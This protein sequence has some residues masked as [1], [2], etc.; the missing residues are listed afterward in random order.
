[1]LRER[2]NPNFVFDYKFFNSHG[3]YKKVQYTV[4]AVATK[5]PTEQRLF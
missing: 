3:M 4:I 2:Y 1:M 5:Y